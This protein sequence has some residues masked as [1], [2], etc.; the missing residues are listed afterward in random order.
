VQIGRDGEVIAISSAERF[1][2]TNLRRA[3]AVGAD[4]GRGLQAMRH[5][6]TAKLERQAA[7][8]ELMPHAW[9]PKPNGGKGRV[10]VGPVIRRQLARLDSCASLQELRASE[11]VAGRW[12]WQTLAS[13]PLAFVTS[14]RK[15][16][17]DH[18]HTA[19]RPDVAAFG[20]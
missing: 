14:W 11:S 9:P 13:L 7:R 4:T 2:N 5:L 20:L 18:W 16:V 6:A 19:R 10:E 3:Q 15:S 8:V 1:H 17:P 12:C